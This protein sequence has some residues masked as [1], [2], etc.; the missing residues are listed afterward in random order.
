MATIKLVLSDEDVKKLEQLARDAS[1]TDIP[2]LVL[3]SISVITWAIMEKKAG[4]KIG[5]FSVKE[6]GEIDVNNIHFPQ[7]VRLKKGE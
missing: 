3:R 6:N 5:A 1:C 7:F 2:H 4:R